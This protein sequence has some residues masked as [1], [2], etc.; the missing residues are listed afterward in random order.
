[1]WEMSGLFP[2]RSCHKDPVDSKK[3]MIVAAGG[4]VGILLGVA[5]ALLLDSIDTSVKSFKEAKDLFGFTL[6][7]VIPTFNTLLGVI[8]TSGKTSSFSKHLELDVP[9][10]FARDMPEFSIEEAYQMLQANLKFLNSDKNIKA[11][12]VTSS[13]AREGKSEVSANLAV[14]MA[15]V[16]Q[17][18]LLVDANMRQPTQHYVWGLLNKVGLS[19]ILVG[20]ARWELCRQEVMPGLDVLTSGVIPPNPVALLDSQ[21]MAA[22]IENFSM[23]YDTIIFDSP[24]LAGIPDS[25]IL[26]KMADGILMVV[27]PGVV[28]SASAQAAKDFLFST[29]QNVLGAVVNGIDINNE[30]D[31]YFYYQKE[32]YRT[33]KS[34]PPSLSAFENEAVMTDKG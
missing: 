7:G 6:L 34:T 27:R 11:I 10:V 3:K 1:M 9:R 8:P 2:L 5:T 23:R 15:Q 32:K 30:P 24:S 13:V 29:G 18:V 12:V 26:G 21:H 14:A 31:S 33:I 20:E 17:R 16:G 19:N 25:N 22:L 28:D 4:F